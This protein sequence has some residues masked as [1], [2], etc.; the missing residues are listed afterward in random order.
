MKTKLNP[1]KNS[2]SALVVTLF[3]ITILAISIAGYLSYTNQQTRLGMR[4][5]TWNMAL[6]VSEAGVEEGL[7]QL[8]NNYANLSADGWTGS[9]TTYSISRSFANG[10][11]YTVSIEYSNSTS[12]TIMAR[13][14][15]N[16]KNRTYSFRLGKY[17]L[18]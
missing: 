8:N 17:S 7:Q 14:F 6:A 3:L 5:Q 18:R 10:N 2:A 11:S 16:P 15:V 1:S 12:P 4:S 13:A 9:G